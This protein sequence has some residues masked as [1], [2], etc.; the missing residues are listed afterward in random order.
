MVYLTFPRLNPPKHATQDGRGDRSPLLRPLTRPPW[1]VAHT[2]DPVKLT[3]TSWRWGATFDIDV[4]VTSVRWL[5]RFGIPGRN[6]CRLNLMFFTPDLLRNQRR[7][8]ARL[9]TPAET[10]QSP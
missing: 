2:G 4:V 1:R 5:L 3:V 7:R 8:E 6:R 10:F 9:D